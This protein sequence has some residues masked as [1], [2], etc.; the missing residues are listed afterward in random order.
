MS[1]LEVHYKTIK[2]LFFGISNTIQN[3]LISCI[4][5]YLSHHT[6]NEFKNCKFFS[7]Q[8]DVITNITQITHVQLS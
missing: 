5:D 2:N 7:V 8:V 1:F 6:K 3:D 4:S